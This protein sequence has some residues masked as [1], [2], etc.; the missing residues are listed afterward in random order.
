MCSPIGASA[1]AIVVT[2]M[3]IDG[4]TLHTHTHTNKIKGYIEKRECNIDYRI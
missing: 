3:L 1:V 4:C 2:S